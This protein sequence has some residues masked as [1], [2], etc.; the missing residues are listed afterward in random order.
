MSSFIQ[1]ASG[2]R[3]VGSYDEDTEETSAYAP[4]TTDTTGIIQDEVPDAMSNSEVSYVQTGTGPFGLGT[5]TSM[6]FHS[7]SD[8]YY[9]GVMLISRSDS[10]PHLHVSP[11]EQDPGSRS[12][13]ESAFSPQFPSAQSEA[14]MGRFGYDLPV[15][16]TS[17]TDTDSARSKGSKQSA[18]GGGGINGGFR[19][20]LK[21]V[22]QSIRGI[23]SSSNGGNRI[24]KKSGSNATTPIIT[25]TPG[26]HPGIL[27]VSGS[28]SP[29]RHMICSGSSGDGTISPP[30]TAATERF[31]GIG[32]SPSTS[33]LPPGMGRLTSPFSYANP[34]ESQRRVDSSISHDH[35]FGH[36]GDATPTARPSVSSTRTF[37]QPAGGT[38]SN[39]GL[40]LA[41]PP[42]G[43]S[44]HVPGLRSVDVV[45]PRE[46]SRW[47]NVR[48]SR[49]IDGLL[50]VGL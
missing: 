29:W 10:A 4:S 23:G 25:R 1:T 38:S 49:S 18:G 37:G 2:R 19:G 17:G 35:T 11:V 15:S 27:D 16:A 12:S 7:P 26:Q 3:Y 13:T 8:R 46:T 48:R 50:R 6:K 14:F 41:R 24:R 40:M 22:K 44:G 39:V 21:S 30:P 36:G 45:P 33:P 47:P 34:P 43:R 9:G 31:N 42:F 28:G 5:P 20:G 32:R